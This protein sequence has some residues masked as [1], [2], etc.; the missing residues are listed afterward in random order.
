MNLRNN[1]REYMFYEVIWFWKTPHI[2][3]VFCLG[4]KW[5]FFVRGEQVRYDH[6]ESFFRGN[7]ISNFTPRG[8]RG[9]KENWYYRVKTTSNDH[10]APTLQGWKSHFHRGINNAFSAMTR[11]PYSCC[12]YKHSNLLLWK[13]FCFSVALLLMTFY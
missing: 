9:V 10:I 3:V 2:I 8:T 7:I 5:P 11:W 12:V 13:Y 1:A 4:A 6:F